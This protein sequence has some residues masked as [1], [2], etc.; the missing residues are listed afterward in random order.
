MRSKMYKN[1]NI[2]FVTCDL[3]AVGMEFVQ[4]DTTALPN[5]LL[6]TDKESG[7][8]RYLGSTKGEEDWKCPPTSWTAAV[9]MQ[10][11]QNA[12]SI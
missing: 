8:I 4:G 3:L 1:R 6:G 10:G 9:S 2:P 12:D 5:E 7:R 11:K